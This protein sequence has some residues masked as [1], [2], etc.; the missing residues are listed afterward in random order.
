M[1]SDS[2]R[3]E[4]LRAIGILICLLAMFFGLFFEREVMVSVAVICLAAALFCEG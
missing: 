1:L 3:R 4:M 2:W